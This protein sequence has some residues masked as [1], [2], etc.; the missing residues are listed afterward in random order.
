MAQTPADPLAGHTPAMQHYLRLKAQQPQALLLYRMGDF[1]ELFF[2]DAVEAARL[3]DITLT[4]RGESGGRKIPMAGV[5]AHALENYLGRLVRRG[6]T[7]A[8]CEQV[9]VPD[10]R[11]PMQRELVRVVT[12]GTLTDDALLDQRRDNLIAAVLRQG[13]HAGLAVLEL[14]SGRF[15]V[16]EPPGEAALAAELARLAPAELLAPEG[17][18]VLPDGPWSVTSRPPWQFEA[19]SAQRRLCEQFGVHDLTGFGC[20]GMALAIGAAGALLQY[21]QDTQLAALP[22]LRGLRVQAPDAVLVLDP[23]TRRNLEIDRSL[24]GDERATLVGVLD[25]CVGAMGSRQLRRWLLGPIRDHAELRR[26][27]AAIAVLLQ[28][29][30]YVRVQE[31]L[32]GLGMS[33]AFSAAWRCAAPGHGILQPCATVWDC[34]RDWLPCSWIWRHRCWQTCAPRCRASSRCTSCSVARSRRRRRPC[35]AMAA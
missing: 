34:C 15:T 23:A 1:Y 4:S 9:G 3:L 19:A 10:G 35:C 6:R 2:D 14:A 25:A 8:I 17:D 5:P 13:E 21:A 20:A 7:V 27:Y 16:G 22:H 12:P 33:S 28:D 30:T 11:G 31:G 29:Q 32:R 26:R 18:S 24:S